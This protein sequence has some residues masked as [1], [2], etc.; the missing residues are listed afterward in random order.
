MLIDNVLI[1]IKNEFE[2]SIL[3][4]SFNGEKK[5]NG[6]EAKKALICSG[7]LINHIHEY[8]KEELIENGINSLSICP[9]KGKT[10]PELKLTGYLKQKKQDISIIPKHLKAT[11]QKISW[12]PLS[13]E[14]KWDSYG[15][16]LT[17]Q[18]LTI[19]V[20]SQ[21]SSVAKNAD[22]LFE[23]THAE[24]TNL[25]EIHK[26]MV[27]GE[28]YLIPTHEYCE[29]SMTKNEVNWNSTHTNIEKYISFFSQISGR[30]SQDES[31]M[32]YEQ[33]SLLIVDFRHQKPKLYK[34]LQELKDDGLVRKDFKIDRD[35]LG[36]QMFVPSLLK[37]YHSRFDA[38]N[39]I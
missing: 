36:L 5:K 24:S 21:L 2:K 39:L 29:E 12:G 11:R 22:T 38:L 33:C 34:T 20:R 13:H 7:R 23:R 9:P 8:I 26:K 37:T 18:I 25:H 16:E 1:E 31:S 14:D 28:V 30:E 35:I 17:E 15:R 32:K 4:A 27:L 19:N 3:T 10:K 6:L